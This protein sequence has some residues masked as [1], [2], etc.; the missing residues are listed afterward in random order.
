MPEGER[1]A[2]GG[3]GEGVGAHAAHT[4]AVARARALGPAAAHVS[5][6]TTKLC[7]HRAIKVLKR[8]QS[9]KVRSTQAQNA[10]VRRSDPGLKGTGSRYKI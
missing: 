4:Q 9:V 3:R 6:A 7:S 8:L 10:S 2:G 1:R 5:P